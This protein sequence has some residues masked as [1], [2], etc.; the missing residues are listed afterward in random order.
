MPDGFLVLDKPPGVSSAAA[1]NPVKRRF[2]KGTKVGHAGTLDPFATGCL[3]ALVG[4]AT[5]LSD[6]VM[7]SPKGYLADLHLG[8]TTATL[9]PE[10]PVEPGPPVPLLTRADVE[11]VLARFVGT[12]EQKPPAFSAMKV[13]GRRAYDL[14]RRGDLVDLPAR[15]VRVDR[16]TLLD[17]ADDRLTLHMTVGKGFYVRSLARDVAQALGTTGYLTALRRTH[18]GP[19]QADNASEELLPIDF[20][21]PIDREAGPVS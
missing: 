10:S 5:K 21:E 17:L 3:V 2:G 19:F 1:L 14:A 4:R 8:A 13:A 6:R 7:Q 11:A 18:V 9:D 15:P 12:I 20:L 16:L